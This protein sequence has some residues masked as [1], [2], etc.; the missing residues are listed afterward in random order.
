[1]PCLHPG[2]VQI[3]ESV[4]NEKLKDYVNVVVFS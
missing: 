3:F 2:D 1:M 4:F